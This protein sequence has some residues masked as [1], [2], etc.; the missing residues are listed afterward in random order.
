MSDVKFIRGL[1]GDSEKVREYIDG[2]GEVDAKL[3]PKV[4]V[5]GD[6]NYK[7]LSGLGK[8][9]ELL[10]SDPSIYI[11]DCRCKLAVIEKAVSEYGEI[12]FVDWHIRLNE[13]NTFDIND[14]RKGSPVKAA[15]RMYKQKKCTWRPDEQRKIP[16]SDFLYIKGN[17][18]VKELIE[19]WGLMERPTSLEQVLMKYIDHLTGRW[20]GSDYYKQYFEIPFFAMSWEKELYGTVKQ[21]PA[22]IS[23][24]DVYDVKAKEIVAERKRKQE[25]KTVV[26]IQ[27]QA[28]PVPVQEVQQESQEE[29]QK[30]SQKEVHQ[31]A[32]EDAP[33]IELPQEPKDTP[34][35]G[36][37]TEVIPEP[38]IQENKVS[39]RM[40]PIDL[41]SW[42]SNLS[43]NV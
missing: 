16:A 23:L 31:V 42:T 13:G 3:M 4:Y 37:V 38:I 30:E 43:R 34:S 39:Y 26:K 40:Y 27:S 7:Y 6:D 35:V 5:F 8:D 41:D 28:F 19:L 9:C 11:D 29:S 32:M 1:W 10:N 33:K 20:R 17:R 18:T 36:I 15:L 25:D 22:F 2:A 24:K 12:V 14:L 21:N